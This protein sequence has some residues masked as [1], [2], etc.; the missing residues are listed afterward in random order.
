MTAAVE[1]RD[2]VVRQTLGTYQTSTVRGLK[3]SCT[4]GA[5]QAAQRLG[6][7]LFGKSL[8][9]ASNVPGP[10]DHS[11][12]YWQ[13]LAEPVFAWAWQSG[14]IEV[15]KQVPEGALRVATGMEAP[16]QK[17]VSAL[18]RHGRGHSEG[19]LLVPGVPEAKTSIDKLRALNTWTD[20]CAQRNGKP[21][22]NGVVFA[23]DNGG[24]V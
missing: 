13:L 22:S 15:G 21:E 18:A 3:A 7:K 6:E 20:W 2:I 5:Q 16:L 8:V 19:L 11:V 12:T 9:T 10:A 23:R 4:T 17:M 1:I 24:V 14:R